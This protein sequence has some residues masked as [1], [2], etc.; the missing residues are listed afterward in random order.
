MGRKGQNETKDQINKHISSLSDIIIS[1]CT[2][3]FDDT[4]TAGYKEIHGF[5][6]KINCK[7]P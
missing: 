2:R 7:C 5:T 4:Q 1:S 6:V 3:I